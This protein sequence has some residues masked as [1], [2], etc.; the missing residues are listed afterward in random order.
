[1]GYPV[2][3]HLDIADPTN[4]SFVLSGNWSNFWGI[5]HEIGHNL[6]RDA[7]TFEGALEVTCNIF[8]MYCMYHVTGDSPMKCE[9]VQLQMPGIRNALVS[10]DYNFASWKSDP[11]IAIGMP[12]FLQLSSLIH[13]FRYFMNI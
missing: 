6:Q 13:T 12:I 7:W 10:G 8:S 9:W 2:V 5:Y 4:D 1:M 3:S 11:G